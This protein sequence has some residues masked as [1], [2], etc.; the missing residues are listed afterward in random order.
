MNLRQGCWEAQWIWSQEG[1]TQGASVAYS[2]FWYH[3][4]LD[5]EPDLAISW[6]AG[7]PQSVSL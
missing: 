2:G 4:D 1:L 3:L 5:L 7:M 6:F